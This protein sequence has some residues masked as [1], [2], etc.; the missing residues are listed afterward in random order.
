MIQ[1]PICEHE[2]PEGAQICAS[3]GSALSAS[4]AVTGGIGGAGGHDGAYTPFLPKNVRLQNNKYAVGEV[5]GQ[6][7]FGITYKGGDMALKRY[8]AIKEF[9]PQGSIR[10]N[11]T[12]RPDRTLSPADY[13]AV[14]AKFIDEA[15]RLA[16]FSHPSIVRVFG[17][18]EENNTAYMVM[19]FLEGQSLLQRITE[20]RSLSE[21]EVVDIAN[22]IGDALAAVHA[23][24][25]IHRDIKPDNIMLT[26]D[27]RVVLIDFGTARSFSSNKTVKQTAMLTP[28]YA[29]L[30]QYG[31]QARFGAYTD[32]YALGATLYHALTG[33]L[34]SPAT[35][36][37][38][39]VELKAPNTIN[40][41]I[42]QGVSNAILWAMKVK[43]NERP[44]SVKAFLDALEKPAPSAPA[45]YSQSTTEF[46]PNNIAANQA[47]IQ[48]VRSSQWVNSMRSYNIHLDGKNIGKI[49]NGKTIEFESTEGSHQLK[50]TIDWYSGD[51]NFRLKTGEKI[52]FIVAATYNGNISIKQQPATHVPPS[53]SSPISPRHDE[54][55]E[56]VEFADIVYMVELTYKKRVKKID[57][58]TCAGCNRKNSLELTKCRFCGLELPWVSIPRKNFKALRVVPIYGFAGGLICGYMSELYQYPPRF[59][60]TNFIVAAL[61]GF[62]LGGYVGFRI[63]QGE[64]KGNNTISFDVGFFVVV[65]IVGII[66]LL[67]KIS[68]S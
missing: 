50:I 15:H 20:K 29:P 32:I 47:T 44:Q 51:Y 58:A 11:S 31:Q 12:L 64:M 40:P 7:G 36:L 27:G 59:D 57:T 2:N 3:C 34:P 5:L 56:R 62:A 23:A 6:G 13:N 63:S 41:N 37:I 55:S 1:C 19:E 42:S 52:C 10:H 14:K 22:K 9:F 25:L 45:P 8:V 17:V 66:M 53:P 26:G 61:F 18:F 43:A 48:I 16:R 54:L 4:G 24:G 30:E 67:M 49:E 60:A 46:R 33:E 68:G 65:V 38:S 21:T 35:D 39:G 28:G